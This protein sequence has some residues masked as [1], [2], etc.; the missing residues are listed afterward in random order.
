MSPRRY[1]FKILPLLFTGLTVASLS[2]Q[3]PPPPPPPA[4]TGATPE[5]YEAVRS[6]YARVSPDTQVGQVLAVH[7]SEPLAAVTGIPT[8]DIREG[9]A[10]TFLNSEESIIAFGTVI[11]PVDDT[12]HVRFVP[13]A[14]GRAPIPGDLVLKPGK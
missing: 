2:C 13:T 9:E 6:R 8:G 3:R 4:P 5:Q 10:V 12:L 11:R 1:T 7:T 14:A